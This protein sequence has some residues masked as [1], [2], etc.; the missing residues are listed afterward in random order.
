MRVLIALFFCLSNLA[1]SQIASLDSLHSKNRTYSYLEEYRNNWNK[2]LISKNNTK[3][4][5]II[6]TQAFD[7]QIQNIKNQHNEAFLYIFNAK[8]QLFVNDFVSKVYHKYL[9]NREIESGN[10]TEKYIEDFNECLNN[11]TFFKLE[12]FLDECQQQINSDEYRDKEIIK[13][14]TAVVTQYN[15]K[16]N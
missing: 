16:I 10:E 14:L 1:F 2:L 6:G 11:E 3:E 15:L 8:E 12:K 4:L 5:I 13:K 7:N 9:I